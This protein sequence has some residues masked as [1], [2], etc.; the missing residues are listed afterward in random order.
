[1]F[2]RAALSGCAKRLLFIAWK[3]NFAGI[4]SF[5]SPVFFP[6]DFEPVYPSRSEKYLSPPVSPL[7]R[8]EI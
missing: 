3:K 4:G 1:M 6:P 5:F 7:S 8:E 2:S